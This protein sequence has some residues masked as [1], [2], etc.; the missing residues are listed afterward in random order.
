MK[1]LIS[2]MVRVKVS[3]QHLAGHEFSSA[4]ALFSPSI[5]LAAGILVNYS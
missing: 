2:A 1:D 3:Q 4:T 5:M